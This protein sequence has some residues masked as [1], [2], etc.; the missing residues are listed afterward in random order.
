MILKPCPFCRKDIPRSIT[1]C[2]YC[3]KDEKGQPVQIDSVAVLPEG[4]DRLLEEELQ[5]LS[6]EDVFAQEQAVARVA[7]KGEAV[8]PAL[9]TVLGHYTKPG[10]SGVAKVLGRIGDR[11][12]IPSLAQAA[13]LGDEDLRIAAVSALAQFHD[14]EAL[15]V[16]LSEA[17]RPHP[18]IQAFIAHLLGRFQDPRVLP[19][20]QKLTSHPRREVSFQAL[21]ALGEAGDPQGIRLLKKCARRRDPMIRAASLSSLRRLGASPSLVSPW[22]LVLGLLVLV[23]IGVGLGWHF[24]R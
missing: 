8:V 5:D 20:L 13:K 14:A 9:V 1:V 16:L 2:P 23:A 19:V 24:H 15:P 21:C 22:L 10:L 12:A 4:Q 11:R 6:S 18:L 3:H 17:E 7:L